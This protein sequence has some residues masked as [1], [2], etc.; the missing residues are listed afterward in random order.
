MNR[1]KKIKY[2]SILGIISNLFL[3]LIKA[4]VSILTGSQAMLAD[5]FNSAG[6]IFSSVITFIG[7]KISSK[8]RDKDHNLG[9]GKAEYI[10]SLLFSLVMIV[11]AC[12]IFKTSLL[13]VYN[14]NIY[15]FSIWLLIVCLIS[16]I[17]KLTLY[18]YTKK[19][20]KEAKSLLL[21]ANSKDHRNDAILTLLNLVS[22][23]LSLFNIYFVDGIV[24][25]LIALWIIISSIKIFIQSYDVLMDKS[26]SEEARQ[27]VYKI[28]KK[29]P[30]I[31]KINHFNSTPIGY[32]YQISLTIFVDGFLST[33][34]S[35]EI[36]DRL[37]KD[38][39]N[40]IDEI[41]LVVIHVNPYIK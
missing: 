27:E 7:N 8:P 32:K 12:F 13:A 5:G 18:L 3:C 37:E 30:E 1:F 4:L 28:I 10:Y 38:I 9:H 6:D 26:I 24:G 25:M 39:I 23:I 35:H 15:E 36:A 33:F 20:A 29:Y 31:I 41:Y 21:D 19:I 2:A 34:E 11:S 17:I 14:K 22:V 40:S 16:I